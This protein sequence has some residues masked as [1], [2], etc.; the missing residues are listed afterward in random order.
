MGFVTLGAHHI[1]AQLT[2]SIC[3]GWWEDY[4]YSCSWS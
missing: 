4:P 3:L 2:A 1:M